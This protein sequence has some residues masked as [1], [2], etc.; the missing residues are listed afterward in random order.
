MQTCISY[1]E[2]SICSVHIVVQNTLAL[3]KVVVGGEMGWED[4]PMVRL[5]L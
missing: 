2:Q 3:H 5:T 4:V 1:L